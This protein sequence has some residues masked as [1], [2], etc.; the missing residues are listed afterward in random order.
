MRKITQVQSVFTAKNVLSPS[1]MADVKGGI[2]ID[3]SLF[4]KKIVREIL[5]DDKR[6]ERPGG[7]ITTL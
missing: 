5:K 6:R 2:S 3:E 4:D 7:G 1:Q